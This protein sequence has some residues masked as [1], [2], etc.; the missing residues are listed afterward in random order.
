MSLSLWLFARQPLGLD[1]SVT[2][3]LRRRLTT[4]HRAKGCV[5]HVYI[6]IMHICVFR[7]E[8][9]RNDALSLCS[10]YN[11]RSLVVSDTFVT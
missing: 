10:H 1:K 5:V 7:K 8:R 4:Q 6:Y 3:Y 9:G 2:G 11:P